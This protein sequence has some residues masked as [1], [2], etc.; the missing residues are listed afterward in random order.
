ML[1]VLT[2]ISG[3]V[4]FV[5]SDG[6]P[7]FK[8]EENISETKNNGKET[9]NGNNDEE[10]TEDSN[11]GEG[12]IPAESEDDYV[13]TKHSTNSGEKRVV[14]YFTSWGGYARGIQ[15]TDLDPNL[16]THINYAFANLNA[17]GEVVVG[18]SWIDL[19]KTFPGDGGWSESVD[20]RGHFKQLQLLKQKYPH[21][22]TLISVGGWTWSKNFSDAAAT[23]AGRRKFAESALTF[24]TKYG[25]DGVDID[26]EYPV[27]G[28]DD[29]KHRPEDREN[30][31]LLLKELRKALDRQGEIDGKH[32]LLSIAAGPNPTFVQNTEPKE[33]M[34]YLDYMNI[35]TYDY[36]GGWQNTTSHNAPLHTD[37]KND[38][39][40][41]LLSVEDTLKAYLDAGVKPEDMNIGLAFY[42]RGWTSV[43]SADNNGLYQEGVAPASAGYGSGTWEGACFDYWDIVENYIGKNGYKRYWDELAQ[44]PYI[45]NGT[46]FIS[47]DDK[48]SIEIKLEYAD[49]LK[50]GGAMFWEFGGDKHKEL[51]KV[52]ADF[53]KLPS[54]S[55]VSGGGETSG[56]ESGSSETAQAPSG[57][58]WNAEKEYSAGE[59][60]TFEGKTY[61]ANWWNQNTKP[62][63]NDEWGAWKVK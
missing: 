49:K 14:A 15:V 58:E 9:S 28:G 7:T 19:E 57:S 52:V 36:H 5:K 55:P 6:L 32:Y 62:D 10:E 21:I 63:P 31:T 33:M 61:I 56:G 47:Y 53:Y 41:L 34:K 23:D 24:I 60:V 12:Q 51:Q 43:T 8:K 54:R 11:V 37:S 46:S 42:G 39:S 50:L 26:W 22:K 27:E 25:F 40:E 59:I 1:L 38:P 4:F 48:E 17:D 20:F 3:Y 29:I 18:D 13:P 2:M 35:M 16:V 44:A 30:Y 45:Y